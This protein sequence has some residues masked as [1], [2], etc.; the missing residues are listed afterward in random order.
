ML[1][2]DK[3]SRRYYLFNVPKFTAGGTFG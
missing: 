3:I 1:N 2:F